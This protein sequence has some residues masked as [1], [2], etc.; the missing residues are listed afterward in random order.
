MN[1][2][3]KSRIDYAV[4]HST[5]EKV[6]K[7]ANLEVE[8]LKARE[9]LRHSLQLYD[10][11]DNFDTLEDISEGVASISE[12]AKAYR[13]VHVELRA[14][15]GNG[16]ANRYPN[17]GKTLEGV[18]LFLKRARNQ[19]KTLKAPDE[20]LVGVGTTTGANGKGD[21]ESLRIN[22]D[23]LDMK[24]KQV[25][26][27][28]DLTSASD[29]SEVTEYIQKMESFLE[30]YFDLCG[31]YKHSLGKE[32]DEEIFKDDLDQISGDVKI[33]KTLRKKVNRCVS[34]RG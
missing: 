7:M 30:E 8:E 33:A 20:K 15:L 28:M 17:Y 29:M 14:E 25:N 13:H 26:S 12:A 18:D 11:I 23:I 6:P 2:R 22:R 32:Y 27:S 5:G 24:I 9:N 21:I 1:L 16:Y 10:D 34:S 31:R 4:Y 19:R 3:S